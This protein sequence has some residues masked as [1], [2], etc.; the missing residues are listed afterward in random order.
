VPCRARGYALHAVKLKVTVPPQV[1]DG[2]PILLQGEGH[3]LSPGRRGDIQVFVHLQRHA[4]FSFD[5]KDIICETTVEMSE[6]ALGGEVTVP[7][8]GGTTTLRLPPGTQSGQ[9]FRL[10]GLGLGGD[11]F[12]KIKVK[13]PIALNEK[14]RLLLRQ[15]QDDRGSEEPGLWR[16]VKKWFW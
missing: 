10:K 3:E 13:T 5:G 14:E 6:A 9:V 4:W 7:T 11:Q 2:F 15:I 1:S 16:R 8:L 12:I